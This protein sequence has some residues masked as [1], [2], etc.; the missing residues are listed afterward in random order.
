MKWIAH[1]LAPI[2]FFTILSWMAMVVRD[3]LYERRRVSRQR[4]SLPANVNLL[5]NAGSPV[6]LYLAL[7]YRL[8]VDQV[9]TGGMPLSEWLRVVV[10]RNGPSYAD[11]D[12]NAADQSMRSKCWERFRFLLL[13]IAFPTMS[14]LDAICSDQE[15]RGSDDR[16]GIGGSTE[17]GFYDPDEYGFFRILARLQNVDIDE[18]P[19]DPCAVAQRVFTTQFFSKH[20]RGGKL[21]LPDDSVGKE[22]F[23]GR[24][25]FEV[26]FEFAATAATSSKSLLR[27]AGDSNVSAQLESIHM[28]DAL[29]DLATGLSQRASR[30]CGPQIPAG[31]AQRIEAEAAEIWKLGWDRGIRA[32]TRHGALEASFTT[33]HVDQLI[34]HLTDLHASMLRV[35]A[36]SSRND[37]ASLVTSFEGFS[38]RGEGV[39]AKF[40]PDEP[41]AA[42]AADDTGW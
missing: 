11:S 17:T 36:P 7:A 41:V 39:P 31:I 1:P 15:K 37:V 14:L 26:M 20:F 22:G 42:S 35:N 32:R 4:T 34:V 40:L 27:T 19:A 25:R 10:D 18:D 2:H 16:W 38:L 24:L 29:C 9:H 12:G 5:Q 28:A 30:C 6:T 33:K 3:G 23:D 13:R 8:L 21:L